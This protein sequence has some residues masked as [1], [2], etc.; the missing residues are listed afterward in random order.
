MSP[1]SAIEQRDNEANERQTRKE[2]NYIK[3]EKK[4]PALYPD[5]SHVFVIITLCFSVISSLHFH[6]PLSDVAGPRP[7]PSQPQP[8]TPARGVIPVNTTS[9]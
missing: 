4:P 3:K 5:T 6:T 8:P 7:S 1:E 9:V 2:S